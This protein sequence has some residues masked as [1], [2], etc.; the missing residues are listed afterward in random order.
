MGQGSGSM[1]P[2]DI[3]HSGEKKVYILSL[4]FPKQTR[5]LCH[6]RASQLSQTKGS[7]L[8]FRPS[9][10]HL[11]TCHQIHELTVPL[12]I[13]SLLASWPEQMFLVTMAANL[14]LSLTGSFL[15]KGAHTAQATPRTE[16]LT[17]E[18]LRTHGRKLL[19]AQDAAGSC[20]PA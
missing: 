14:P 5:V 1:F 13:S 8:S 7:A 3:R 20:V 11:L 6:L 4:P 17:C 2:G 16:R 12:R 15:G 9:L 10:E 18:L 19:T